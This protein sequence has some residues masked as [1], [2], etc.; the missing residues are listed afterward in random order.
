MYMLRQLAAGLALALTSALI[1][2]AYAAPPSKPLNTSSFGPTGRVRAVQQ[3]HMTFN[4]EVVALGD[5]KAAAP[6]SVQCKGTAKPPVARWLD[7][8]RWVAEFPESL[9]DGV[10]CTVQPLPTIALDGTAVSMPASWSFNTGGPNLD[11][12]DPSTQSKEDA[13][14]R[15]YASAPLDRASL[16]HLRCTVDGKTMPVSFP[17]KPVRK[18]EAWETPYKEPDNEVSAQC[19]SAPL[20]NGAT[21]VWT[22]DKRIAAPT[23]LTNLKD[24][25]VKLR[26]RPEL[27]A[28]V[29]CTQQLKTPGCDRRYPVIVTFSEPLLHE[30]AKTMVLRDRNGKTFTDTSL[31]THY[32]NYP[33]QS[34][35][36]NPAFA[37]VSPLTFEW[38][39]ALVDVDKRALARTGDLNLPIHLSSLPPYAGMARN[40][41]VLE[42]RPGE[43]AQWSVAARGERPIQARS[44][45]FDAAT[46]SPAL[47]A[48]HTLGW[49]EDKIQAG[50]QPRAYSNSMS[51]LANLKTPL[52]RPTEQEI[53]LPTAHT[54]HVPIP[55]SGFGNW[56][57]EA[58]SAAYRQSYAA[59][60][61][62][63]IRRQSQKFDHVVSI[64]GHYSFTWDGQRVANIHVKLREHASSTRGKN[65][66]TLAFNGP[67]SFDE[68]QVS[69]FLSEAA[70]LGLTVEQPKVLA[71][72]SAEL[73][74]AYSASRTAL[75]QLTNLN[76][77][78]T[79]SS[80]GNSLIWITAL[81]S[82]HSVAGASVEL[83]TSNGAGFEQRVQ[84]SSD[85]QGRV[86]V[87]LNA[88]AGKQSPLVQSWIVVRLG[89][90]VVVH[91][92]G[93]DVNT[94]YRGGS[95]THTVIDR[96]LFHPGETVSMSHVIRLPS[97]EGWTVPT[98]RPAHI[99]IFRTD[100][101]ALVHKQE[102]TWRDDG[103]AESS[104]TIPPGA[105]LGKY[106]YGLEGQYPYS[107][108]GH[109]DFQI[110]EFRVPSF[111][112]SL[113]LGSRWQG[114]QQTLHL[115][116]GL[117][118]VAGGAVAGLATTLNGKYELGVVSPLAG[119]SFLD[120]E[121]SRHQK[122]TFPKTELKLG[123]DGHA[124][125]SIVPPKTDWPLTLTAEMQFTDASGE[126]QTR[127]ERMS[128]WPQ[129]QKLGARIAQSLAAGTATVSIVALDENNAPVA[130][131]LVSIDA[132]EFANDYVGNILPIA[133]ESR[134]TACT[135]TTGKDGKGQCTIPWKRVPTL[136]GWL[137]RARADGMSSATAPLYR[138]APQELTAQ[139]E[140]I[141]KRISALPL[142]AG[143]ADRLRV[144]APFLPATLLLSVE[145]EGV[146]HSQTHQLTREEQEISLPTEAHYSPG[147]TVVATFVRGSTHLPADQRVGSAFKHTERLALMFNPANKALQVELVPATVD[148]RPGTLVPVR[149]KARLP[150]SDKAAAGA[151]VTLIAVDDALALLKPNLTMS[152]SEHFWFDRGHATLQSA[153]SEWILKKSLGS[154]PDF[155]PLTESTLTLFGAAANSN[156]DFASSVRDLSHRSNRYPSESSMP[157]MAAPSSPLPKPG[158]PELSA[159]PPSPPRV[160][161]STLALWRAHVTL[162]ANG[163][164]SIEVPLPDSLTRWRIVAIASAGTDM[165]GKAEALIATSK[166]FEILQGLPLSVRGADLVHQQITVRNTS[167]ASATLA[168]SANASMLRHPDQPEPAATV[169]VPQGHAFAQ[170]LKLAAGESRIV[171]WPVAVPDGV[172]ALDWKIALTSSTDNS[173]VDALEIRQNVV[174]QAPLTVRDS[175]L[176]AVAEG[177]SLTVARP[178]DALPGTGAVLVQWQ[179][180]LAK[181]AIEGARRWMREYAYS[182][183][184]QRSSRAAVSG[185]IGSWNRVTD[186]LPKHLDGGLVR[187]FPETAGSE[188]LTAYVLTLADAYQLPL[189]EKD[190]QAMQAAL[191]NR[192]AAPVGTQFRDPLHE[193]AELQ[194]RLSMQAALRKELGNVA[195]TVPS[196]LD[197]LPVESLLDWASYLLDTPATAERDARLQHAANHLRNR[198][199]MHGSHIVWR[200]GNSRSGWMMWGSDA[201]SARAA[202]VMQRWHAINPIWKDELVLMPRSI[203]DAQK[204]GSW[205]TTVGNALNVAALQRFMKTGEQGP[206]TGVSSASLEGQTRS[207]TWPGQVSVKLPL[208]KAG[209]GTLVLSHAGTGAPWA[210]V[211]VLA[212]VKPSAP[213]V[214][215]VSV[216][217]TVTALEQRVPGRWSVGDVLKVRLT[218][219]T[220]TDLGWVVVHDPI[221]SG[222]TILGKGLG[223]EGAL[224]QEKGQAYTGHPSSIERASDSFRAYYERIHAREWHVDYL[225]RLNNAGAFGLP[226]TRIEAMYAPEIFGEAPNGSMEVQP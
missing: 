174:L 57:V 169:G 184:E 205:S 209:N 186:T 22:W 18:L 48:L 87:P 3:V 28:K 221:P 27:F 140:P 69:A 139:P 185:D 206:V 151:S 183:Y 102:L 211:S 171:S 204:H 79:M 73:A 119:F 198:Y 97:T 112:A 86:V 121:L 20:R 129:R 175:T 17:V 49:T 78:A 128:V 34:L 11:N 36:F 42:W 1:C 167:R 5:T 197:V 72:K 67:T 144:R 23:G 194:L 214:H 138:F 210:N 134:L 68:D 83:W 106:S 191:R 9:R 53:A 14:V 110:E 215:G 116:P 118:Y 66:R 213:V 219:R 150:G 58:D 12:T 226:A 223:R 217:K 103:T 156:N 7:G 43:S 130:G 101:G 200:L 75:V 54:S 192:L 199:T 125:A 98:D 168:V 162:D 166:P 187:Y 65:A 55:L 137:F 31:D 71:K 4:R 30:H 47:L 218:M 21:V 153:L 29:S 136:S 170:R 50:Q 70:R 123:K 35:S 155:N 111:E 45:Q 77:H 201:L 13:T 95:V 117:S 220:D 161:F 44:W 2:L 178:A 177:H 154:A 224:A 173:V 84:T 25:Q 172:V 8:R 81:D 143:E 40:A 189:P 180:S 160:N 207:S 51:R 164:A 76:V 203:A 222:A 93:G 74:Q 6:A 109:R 90:D 165:F 179:D 33:I 159:A 135:I 62:E 193:G 61:H 60:Q 212:S 147:V 59:Q 89:A 63:L 88:F 190:K 46:P 37:A 41:G 158:M 92:I 131:K 208:L 10:I 16:H 108:D 176:L 96:A 107:H 94:P 15:F 39:A 148:A 225:V 126:T 64:D 124:L 149:I 122:F 82:G 38:P 132:A 120:M 182:C 19:G 100:S 146:L 157:V 24:Q 113:A 152:L 195:P 91:R 114:A 202:L 56:L 142:N 145:R 26:V 181:S 216:E 163:E 85:A 196:D 127:S 133:A 104:W 80:K 188:T 32:R 105:L 99:Q 115:T 52:P 141:L